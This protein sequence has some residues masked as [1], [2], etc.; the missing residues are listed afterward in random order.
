MNETDPQT[1]KWAGKWPAACDL[2]SRDVRDSVY[3][4]DAQMIDGPWALVCPMCH[5]NHCHG[6]GQR[7]GQKYDSET[8]AKLGG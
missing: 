6:V 2:C 7:I 4:Y 1:K 8:L 5:L 3:F